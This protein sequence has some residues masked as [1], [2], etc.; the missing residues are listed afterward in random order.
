MI[1]TAK[2]RVVGAGLICVC[3]YSISDVAQTIS[4]Q[5]AALA[6]DLS[7]LT[8]VTQTKHQKPADPLNVGLVGSSDE[9]TALMAAAGWTVPVSVT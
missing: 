7:Q 5:Q 9:I 6:Q 2:W 1:H 4:P 3:C 8:W